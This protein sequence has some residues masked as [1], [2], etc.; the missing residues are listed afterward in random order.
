MLQAVGRGP[1]SAIGLPGTH[2]W[3]ETLR[4]SMC[5]LED[6]ITDK[7]Q[8]GGSLRRALSIPYADRL[9]LKLGADT[10]LRGDEPKTVVAALPTRVGAENAATERNR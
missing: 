3:D 2:G 1:A 5:V 10:L 8:L 6:E 7:G 9:Q 4:L